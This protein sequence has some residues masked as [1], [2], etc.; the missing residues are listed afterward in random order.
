MIDELKQQT[1]SSFDWTSHGAQDSESDNANAGP[2]TD[3]RK[4]LRSRRPLASGALNTP[5]ELRRRDVVLEDVLGKGAFGTVKRGTLKTTIGYV[6]MAI[7]VAV[8]TIEESGDTPEARQAFLDEAVVTWQ[9][10]CP[11]APW[12]GCVRCDTHAWLDRLCPVAGCNVRLTALALRSACSFD[13]RT[14]LA[15]SGS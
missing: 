7:P 6:D 1:G 9:V 8:K 15:C 12:A 5:A 13:I 10:C 14:W 11:V 4:Q 3:F 2:L